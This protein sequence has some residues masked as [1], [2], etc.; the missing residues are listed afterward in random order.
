MPQMLFENLYLKL[1]T[2]CN[3]TWMSFTVLKRR[4]L[5]RFYFGKQKEITIL[6]RCIKAK[7]GKSLLLHNQPQMISDL[8]V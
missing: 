2:F 1:N 6:Y 4:P 5:L 7:E 8:L 3:S